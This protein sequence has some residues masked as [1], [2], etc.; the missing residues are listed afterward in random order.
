MVDFLEQDLSTIQ[1]EKILNAIQS[2]CLSNYPYESGGLI[3]KD[4]SIKTYASQINDCNRYLPIYEFY[5]DLVKGENV[6]ASFHSHLYI[7]KPSDD[8][9]FFIKNYDIPIIIY[10]LNNKAYLS[11]NIKNETNLITWP[12]EKTC[13]CKV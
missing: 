1:F 9:L 5:I 2:Y 4:G 12:F 8:D 3:Y 6:L 11:V 10:S 7:L 13:V